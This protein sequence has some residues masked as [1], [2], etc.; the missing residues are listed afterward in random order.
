MANVNVFTEIDPLREVVVH[1]PGRE[2]M[3]MTPDSRDHFLFDDLLYTRHAQMEHDW[4]T[5]VLGEHLGIKLHYFHQMLTEALEAAQPQDLDTLLERTALIQAEPQPSEQRLARLEEEI[6][7][8]RADLERLQGGR[9]PAR[10]ARVE[11]SP[12]EIS[13]SRIGFP[14]RSCT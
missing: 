10:F 9:A 2:L 1:R 6:A 3:R 13:A 11:R 12:T 7:T 5:A 8:L 4:F 14:F